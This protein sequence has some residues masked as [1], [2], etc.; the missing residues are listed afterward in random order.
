VNQATCPV[1]GAALAAVK[2]TGGYLND[3]QFESVR[4]GAWY[5]DNVAVDHGEHAKRGH[6]GFAYFWSR[7]VLPPTEAQP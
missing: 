1:C 2:N 4:A 3:D 5:C 6:S 7:E